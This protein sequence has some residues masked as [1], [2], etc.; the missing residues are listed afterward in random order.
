MRRNRLDLPR[1]RFALLAA[2]SF[3]A[4]PGMAAEPAPPRRLTFVNDVAPILTKASCNSGGCHAKAGNGQ[5]GFRLSL[6]GFEPAEDY[7]HIVREGHGRRVFP[8]SPE[9]SLLLLK[10]SNL[11]PH[12]GGKRLDQSSEG[13]K[14]LARW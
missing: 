13:Y 1:L 5:N 11:V 8:A 3:Y 12:G 2:V 9:Q 6:L 14:R 4:A 7:E 10:A